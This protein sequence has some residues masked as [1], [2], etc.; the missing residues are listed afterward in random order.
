MAQKRSGN[1]KN[2]I[3]FSMQPYEDRVIS[4]K[5]DKGDDTRLTPEE[6]TSFNDVML[7]K[8]IVWTKENADASRHINRNADLYL[9]WLNYIDGP[10]SNVP[11]GSDE[12]RQ[13]RAGLIHHS[14]LGVIRRKANLSPADFK[15]LSLAEV[16]GVIEDQHV[17]EHNAKNAAKRS[18]GVE[19]PPAETLPFG[20]QRCDVTNWLKRQGFSKLVQ[21]KEVYAPVMDALMAA[22][23][24]EISRE[25]RDHLKASGCDLK[26][27]PKQLRL[28]IDQ[29]GLTI[30]NWTLKELES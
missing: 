12:F 21:I 4:N 28:I 14:F 19:S 3:S 20:L 18:A 1:S 15:A 22:A 27:A 6:Q 26:N 17:K 8:T 29:L 16:F 30:E 25:K 13:S 10:L 24:S 7:D 5:A 11:I 23:P 9:W 2:L